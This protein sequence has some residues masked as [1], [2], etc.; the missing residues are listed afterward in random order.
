MLAPSAAKP[1]KASIP[2][3]WSMETDAPALVGIAGGKGLW[4]TTPVRFGVISTFVGLVK[5]DGA[6]DGA[7]SE[8]IGVGNRRT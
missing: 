7:L 6:K 2:F 5:R 1:P 4:S 3:C 8:H